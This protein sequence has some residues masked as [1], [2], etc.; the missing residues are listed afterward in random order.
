MS[1]I[2]K[3]EVAKI[4]EIIGTEKHI[5][6]MLSNEYVSIDADEHIISASYYTSRDEEL[7]EYTTQFCDI[8]DSERDTIH[9]RSCDLMYEWIIEEWRLW[10]KG[11]EVDNLVQDW[12]DITKEFGEEITEDN[13][14]D[15]I[16]DY[17]L[18]ESYV[19][20]NVDVT[21]TAF[22]EAFDLAREV[23]E[24]YI[25]RDEDFVERI[26]S[27]IYDMRPDVDV[28]RA[29]EL[30]LHIIGRNE[31]ELSDDEVLICGK[32]ACLI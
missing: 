19:C 28:Y 17:Y 8:F 13:I 26:E 31:L 4:A 3:F 16:V 7:E 18:E 6:K 25:T 20:Y 29:E 12:D 24:E 9:C 15:V 21:Y 30:A 23:I 1:E 27:K 2:V 32:V 10:S 14:T 11:E 5:I 22:G